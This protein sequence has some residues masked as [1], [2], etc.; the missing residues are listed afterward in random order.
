[1]SNLEL[2]KKL[3]QISFCSFD[4]LINL[5]KNFKF[6]DN[7][8]ENLWLQAFMFI[9]TWSEVLNVYGEDDEI[10]GDI[11]INFCST[12]KNKYEFGIYIPKKESM[13]LQINFGEM[14]YHQYTINKTLTKLVRI[15]PI[16]Q[17]NIY[18][19]LKHESFV[20]MRKYIN[21]NKDYLMA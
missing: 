20:K 17:N 5:Y 4:E 7:K 8:N 14:N 11:N 19:D 1:M 12:D 9:R 16:I 13:K 10:L 18:F 21:E 15:T 3:A 2:H 6:F